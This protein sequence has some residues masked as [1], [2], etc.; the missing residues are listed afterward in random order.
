V[1]LVRFLVLVIAR[2]G[3]ASFVAQVDVR[4]QSPTG[5]LWGSGVDDRPSEVFALLGHGCFVCDKEQHVETHFEVDRL[6]LRG[7]VR[8]GLIQLT[9]LGLGLYGFQES[10]GL[11]RVA[12]RQ[13]VVYS[14]R[15][16]VF[17][18]RWR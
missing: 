13:S 9:D 17:V 7:A 8:R 11:P 2:L 1:L 14:I 10:L 5:F 4:T 16:P 3:P 18:R 12:L 6:E 15:N